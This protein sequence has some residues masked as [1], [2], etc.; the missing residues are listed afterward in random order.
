[1]ITKISECGFEISAALMVSLEK[2]NAE[3]FLEVYKGV[4]QEYPTMVIELCSGPCLV[5]EIRAQDVA[6]VFRDFVGP[7]DPVC[8]CILFYII[9][10]FIYKSFFLFR[11]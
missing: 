2:A 1:V 10:Y 3:E 11:S 5:L 7:A 8:C 6:H 4:V 9:D